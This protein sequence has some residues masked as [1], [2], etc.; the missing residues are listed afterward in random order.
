MQADVLKTPP[1][2]PALPA[3]RSDLHFTVHSQDATVWY[4]IKSPTQRFLRLGRR[5]YFIACALDGQRP[6]D[7]VVA[8]VHQ[9]DPSL[10]VEQEDVMQVVDW[11]GKAGLL[12]VPNSPTSAAPSTRLQINPI[13]MKIP[14]LSGQP[15][16]RLGCWLAPLVCWPTLV[17]AALLW[18][19]AVASVLSHWTLFTTATGRLFVSDSWLWWG[20][21]WLVLKSA[22]EL[23][24]AVMAVRVDSPI[25]SAGIS[26]IFLAPVPYVDL[27]DLWTISN[28]WQRMLCCAGGMLVEI[29]LAA[30]AAIVAV[31]TENQSLQYFCCA[32]ATMGT[33]TTIAF[34]ANPLIRFDGYYIVS[35]CVNYPNLYT[36]AQAAAKQF[37]GK[38]LRPWR[39]APVR[40]TVLLVSY[41]LACYQYR[42][43]MMVSLAIGTVLALQGIGVVLVAWG[44]YAT[45]LVPLLAARRARQSQLARPSAEAGGRLDSESRATMAC[46]STGS[47]VQRALGQYWETIS[48]GAV[49]AALCTLLTVVPAPL[50]PATPGYVALRDP[51]CIR[52]EADGFLSQVMVHGECSVSAGDLIAR[53]SNPELDLELKLKRLE[54]LKTEETIALKRAQGHLAELQAAGAQGESLALQV[55]Q[56]ESRV[57]SLDVRSPA[58]GRLVQ[59]DLE[60]RRGL[61]LKAGEPL[62]LIARANEIEI[63]GSVSQSDVAAMREHLGEVLDVH[64]SGGLAFRGQLEKLEPRALDRLET[65]LLAAIYGG[66]IPVQLQTTPA[67]EEQLKLMRPRFDLR[68]ALSSDVAAHLTPGQMVWI[69]TPGHSATLLDAWCHWSQNKWQELVQQS[70]THN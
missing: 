68:L 21:A 16:E 30:I 5:E 46:S 6:A 9:L 33:L 55:A 34:N 12:Q 61:F 4:A 2:S 63:V 13:Y 1:A 15:L 3:V 66:P 11:L 62:A 28:R 10:C 43:V 19:V 69:R 29:T 59:N 22:H 70:Q 49:V 65:P 54:L 47:W 27:S 38:C 35:D 67:G 25:R 14:L 17:I 45:M 53:L 51:H 42:I 41:G 8:A 39:P 58:S 36:D 7:A 20:A 24:H 37:V 44:A 18:L 48:G 60:S 23:G 52:A 26:L 32:L 57:Q 40:M 56:L 31:T 64:V 50:Q